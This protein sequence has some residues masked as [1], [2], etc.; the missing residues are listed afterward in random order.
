MQKR[1]ARLIASAP[2]IPLL[3]AVIM[4]GVG[5]TGLLLSLV[6]YSTA[7]AM[8]G[9]SAVATLVWIALNRPETKLDE[10]DETSQIVPAWQNSSEL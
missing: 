3:S 9:G 2:K 8:F 4:S 6:G 1:A 10:Q 7:L 5:L